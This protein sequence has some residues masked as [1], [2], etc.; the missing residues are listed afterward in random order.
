MKRILLYYPSNKRSIAIESQILELR[1]LGHQILF[2]TT[3]EKGDIHQKLEEE[4]FKTCTNI[5]KSSNS[6]LYYLNN[7]LFLIRFC[8]VHNIDLVFSN[9]QNVN[10]IAVL[11]QFFIKSKVI[12]FRHHFKFNK[13]NFGI[14]LQVNKTEVLFDKVINRLAKKIVVPSSGVH[15]GML[16]YEKVS[17][18]KLS[19][20]P[21]LYDFSKYKIPSAEKVE[22]IKEQ[23]P[24]KLRVIMIARLIPFKRH[25]LIFPVIKKL[26]DKGLDIKLLVFDEGPESQNLYDY[27]L[28]NKLENHIFMLGFKRNLLDYMKASDLI[29]HPSIT[30]ASNNVIKE[31]GLQEKAVAVCKGVGDFDDYIQHGKNGYFMDIIE[32]EKDA[33]SII[34]TVYNSP[35]LINLLGKNLKSTIHS[36]FGNSQS[37]I[38][39]YTDLIND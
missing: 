29:I 19:I 32:P 9:L 38:N 8:R 21:Y 4:G 14:P 36:T 24:A 1:N 27:I 23:F 12:A 28:K 33:E 11:S 15:N 2:L 26:V 22:K 10:F 18:E 30:E 34:E 7:I 37:V 3:C 13:R 25:I 35:E 17:K 16:Q 31:I 6:L 39:N 5:A 20:I